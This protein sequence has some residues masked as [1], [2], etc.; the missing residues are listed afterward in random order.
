MD[1]SYSFRFMDDD[2]NRRLLSLL[3]SAHV[4]H[5][6]G[7]DGVIYYSRDD[8]ET[9]GNRLLYEVRSKVFPE[10]QLL[11]CPRDWTERYKRYMVHHGIPFRQELF[12]DELGFFLPRN[13]RPHSWNLERTWT[14]HP[15]R[16]RAKLGVVKKLCEILIENRRAKMLAEEILRD[17]GTGAISDRTYKRLG[18]WCNPA[19]PEPNVQPI[20][21]KIST[22]LFGHVINRT[23]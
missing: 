19:R 1:T 22:E 7:P 4:E 23:N 11:S 15:I 9:V 18:R 17:L 16:A 5:R 12:N 8:E 14:A 20:A 13:H 3:K 2:L 6:V 10:W 21:V